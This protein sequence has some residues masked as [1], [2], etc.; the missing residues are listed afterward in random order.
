MYYNPHCELVLG[1]RWTTTTTN[2]PG[3][4]APSPTRT[5]LMDIGH[6][7]LGWGGRGRGLSRLGHGL[8]VYSNS[9]L[10][11]RAYSEPVRAGVEEIQI[12]IS[13]EAL[14]YPPPPNPPGHGPHLH[15]CSL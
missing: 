8:Q 6:W 10:N 1:P 5:S 7:T 9:K 4:Q 13:D 15:I 14:A 12:Q 2:N 11:H 3:T